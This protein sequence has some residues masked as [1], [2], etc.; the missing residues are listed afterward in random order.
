[1]RL[2][3]VPGS[4]E[5]NASYEAAHSADPTR[6]KKTEKSLDWLCDW[7]FKSSLFASFEPY[8]R[9]RK[10]AV[11]NEICDIRLGEAKG[12]ARLGELPFAKMS[13]SAVRKLRDL[14]AATP[15]AANYRLK[16]VAALF[17][18]AVKNEIAAS[19]PAAGIEKIETGST[20]YYTWSERDLDA[21][22]AY[23]P[24]G[25]RARLAF[26]VMIYLGVRR[27]DAVRLGPQ[28]E[29]R[30]GRSITFQVWKGR[31]KY[32]KT[33]TLPIL[34]PL[35]HSIDSSQVGETYL[36]TQAGKPHAS[37][38]SFGNWFRD[39]CREA[40]LPECSPHGLRKAAAVRCAEAGAT[41]H[42]LMAMFGWDDP[43]MARVYT[44]MAEQKRMARSAAEKM[45]SMAEKLENIS[46]SLSHQKEYVEKSTT[47]KLSGA[48][49]RTRT[50]T[51][52][53]AST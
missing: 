5:F 6:E 45:R 7:Y 33:L 35:R 3:G 22:E 25:S 12:A 24:I 29:S 1:M 28:Q 20:G 2:K 17:S 27:S 15:E 23:W 9:R 47:Y 38:D 39:C 13:K 43:A 18:W 51:P 49:K 40:G 14:K 50:S 36:L 37:G 8:T 42:E 26:D 16:Q 10:R 48:Q 32:A 46:H 21:F 30:D 4:A 31:K 53:S 19:N 11:L 41:E 34:A 44:R 52:C